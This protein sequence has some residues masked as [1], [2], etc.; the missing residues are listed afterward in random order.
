MKALKLLAVFVFAVVLARL[1]PAAEPSIGAAGSAAIAA[2]GDDALLYIHSRNPQ[3]LLGK[4]NK[5]ARTANPNFNALDRLQ[6]GEP[7]HNK[8]LEGVDLSQPITIILLN[9]K[10]YGTTNN[11]LVSLSATDVDTFLG[12]VGAD[13][14]GGAFQLNTSSKGLPVK[15]YSRSITKTDKDGYE[16]ALAAGQNPDIS[17]F[18]KKTTESFFV[19]VRGKQLVIGPTKALVEKASAPTGQPPAQQL[20]GDL[21]ATFRM[22][23]IMGTYDNEIKAAQGQLTGAMAMMGGGQ[24]EQI[25]MIVDLMM[26]LAKA[27]QTTELAASLADGNLDISFA[28]APKP[29]TDLSKFLAAQ[30]ASQTELFKF[31]PTQ[32]AIAFTVAAK[33]T[34]E[35]N[36]LAEKFIKM[37]SGLQGINPAQAQELVKLTKESN[38]NWGGEM[39]WY[40]A[41]GNPGS[42]G[43]TLVM[44]QKVVDSAKARSLS[45]QAIKAAGQVKQQGFTQTQTYKKDVAKIGDISLD[46]VTIETKT[47]NPQVGQMIAAMGLD[48]MTAYIAYIPKFV[49]VGMTYGGGAG[50][51][52]PD[53][54]GKGINAL[55]AGQ[56]G[57]LMES[58]DYQAATRGFPANACGLFYMSFER[59]LQA[60]TAMVPQ[61]AAQQIGM[62]AMM[63]QG[64]GINLSGYSTMQANG[65]QATLRIPIQKIQDTIQRIQQQ[66]QGGVPPM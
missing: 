25:Q 43:M 14:R 19:G 35:A 39:M 6:I 12:A 30:T 3:E 21:V 61:E 18:Q 11:G 24:A 41:P 42:R 15:E 5:I 64:S 34:A 38:A 23:T 27:S 56:S 48:N 66:F 13:D 44:F 40:I 63:L 9:S 55:K 16:K 22:P 4:I 33:T 59:M 62:A 1:A 31:V 17:D 2:A 7:I 8:G 32:S 37:T 60:V 36:A 51:P 57:G 28:V 49:V 65:G 29:N 10:K 54:L 26:D 50:T 58:A 52:P 20:G 46:S 47:D 45:E 53:A